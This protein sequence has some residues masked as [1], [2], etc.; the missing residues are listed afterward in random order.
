M[1]QTSATPPRRRAL[2]ELDRSIAEAERARARCRLDLGVAATLGSPARA[3]VMLQL[4]EERLARLQRSR[5]VL[6]G[7]GTSRPAGVPARS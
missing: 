3:R 2:V 5:E 4:A 7:E 6:L 1:S